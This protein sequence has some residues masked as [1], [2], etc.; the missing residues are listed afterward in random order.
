[1]ITK[2][3]WKRENLC[4]KYLRVLT[5]SDI[6]SANSRMITPQIWKGIRKTNHIRQLP[7]CSQGKPSPIDWGIWRRILK[8]SICNKDRVLHQPLGNWLHSTYSTIQNRWDWFW[9][10]S[11]NVLYRKEQEAWY[12][13]SPL[14]GGRVTRRGGGKEFRYYHQVHEPPN[15]RQYSLTTIVHRKNILSM[16]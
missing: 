6:T 7:W 12:K 15:W 5:I 11:S 2:R 1:M 8:R 16:E 3:E 14:T 4:R 13:Y 9:D 10:E